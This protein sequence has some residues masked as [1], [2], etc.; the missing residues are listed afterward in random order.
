MQLPAESCSEDSVILVRAMKIPVDPSLEPARRK[1]PLAKRLALAKLVERPQ[2]VARN[3]KAAATRA[4][5]LAGLVHDH[6]PSTPAKPRGKR[7][8]CKFGPGDFGCP[9]AIDPHRIGAIIGRT[10]SL[11]LVQHL[12]GRAALRKRG[13]ARGP[14]MRGLGKHDPKLNY[15]G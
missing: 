8:T 14:M 5:N 3:V 6:T 11:R 4:Q 2:A 15:C 12:A 1:R 9:H 13:R 7:Q 10:L